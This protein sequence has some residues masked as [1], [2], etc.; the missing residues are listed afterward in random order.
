MTIS[1]AGHGHDEHRLTASVGCRA[2]HLSS[3]ETVSHLPRENSEAS[4]GAVLQKSNELRRATSRSVAH[5]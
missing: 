5:F 4:G 1:V 2:R 3:Q